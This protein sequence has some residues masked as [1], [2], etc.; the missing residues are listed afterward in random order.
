[1]EKNWALSVDQCWMHALQFL[2]HLIYLLSIL[3]RCNG[4]SPAFRK[5]RWIRRVADHHSDHDLL[6]VQVWLWE[7]LWSCFLSNHWAGGHWLSHTIHFSLHVTVWSRNVLLLLHRIWEDDTSK[8]MIFLIF[9]QL[10]RHPL[11][12][13]FH[14]S[15]L[16]QMSNDYRMVNIEFFGSFLYSCERISFNDCF[17]LVVVNFWRPAAVVLIFQALISFAKL[18]EPPLHCLFISSPWAKGFGNVASCLCCFITHFWTRI[19]KWPEFVFCLTLF[20]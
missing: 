6:L 9:R 20:P 10:V 13:L 1:M 4:F 2:V 18:L 16:L 19:R 11:I 14:L 7:V 12:E 8:M 17:Q 5:L 3:L 15:T